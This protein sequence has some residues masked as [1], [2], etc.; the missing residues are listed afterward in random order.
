MSVNIPEY[1]FMARDEVSLKAQIDSTESIL[2]VLVSGF[3][4]YDSHG[5]IKDIY[6]FSVCWKNQVD[7]TLVSHWDIAL[8]YETEYREDEL[9]IQRNN[10]WYGVWSYKFRQAYLAMWNS[11]STTKNYT[12][13]KYGYPYGSYPTDL[14]KSIQNGNYIV[15]ITTKDLDL[16]P[17]QSTAY[18]DNPN[19]DPAIVSAWNKFK[20]MEWNSFVCPY[21]ITYEYIMTTSP[22]NMYST[23]YYGYK[24]RKTYI[25]YCNTMQERFSTMITSLNYFFNSLVYYSEVFQLSKDNYGKIY[26]CF[27]SRGDINIDIHYLVSGSSSYYRVVC[28]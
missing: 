7:T 11:H 16:T 18:V 9:L 23:D 2:G 12:I 3:C 19:E 22:T 25:D 26:E 4:E 24:A 6:N 14:Q 8:L 10:K 27:R 20:I 15:C 21:E 1:P 13:Y 5:S 17:F 28:F